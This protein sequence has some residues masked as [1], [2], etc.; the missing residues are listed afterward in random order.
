MSVYRFC[1]TFTAILALV[2]TS[3]AAFANDE[4]ADA[5]AAVEGVNAFDLTGATT[6]ADAVDASQ[7]A[8]TFYT[9]PNEDVWFTLTA[10]AD[11]AMDLTTCIGGAG[12]S[13]DTDM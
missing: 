5:T 4:C 3:P 8:S 7:C 11:G 9:G 10:P 13:Q 6:S 2:I 12:S 1:L